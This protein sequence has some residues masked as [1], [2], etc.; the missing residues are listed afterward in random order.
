[1]PCSLDMIPLSNPPLSGAWGRPLHIV[2]NETGS[3]NRASYSDNVEADIEGTK[4]STL[5][6]YDMSMVPV[7]AHASK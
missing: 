3:R 5:L 4:D 6:L 2:G 1:M 7:S